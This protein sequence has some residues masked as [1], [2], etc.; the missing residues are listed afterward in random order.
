MAESDTI[1]Q[2]KLLLDSGKLQGSF[3]DRTVILI[4]RHDQSGAF[5]LI[6]NRPTKHFLGTVA[7]EKVP[8]HLAKTL[9][10][11]GGPVQTEVLSFLLE[12]APRP[13]FE[14][15]PNLILGHSLDDL[16]HHFDS[17]EEPSRV[18]A[19]AGYAGWAPGQLEQEQ[20]NGCWINHPASTAFVFHTHPQNL[21][22]HILKLK[23]GLYRLLAD[24]P[25]NPTLN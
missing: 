17:L 1:F 5:G 20:K 11:M 23:G 9:I 22:Q 6:L 8:S 25:D 12:T 21:W 2:G 15:L 7:R 4:C 13:E 19:F 24:S 18:R 3:F 14:I 16:K 10:Y